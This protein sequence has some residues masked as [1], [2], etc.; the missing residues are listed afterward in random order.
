[1]FNALDEV[2]DDHEALKQHLGEAQNLNRQKLLEQEE[3]E[4]ECKEVIIMFDMI[5]SNLV[6]CKC[7]SK[8]LPDH[9]RWRWS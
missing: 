1:M 7:Q 4:A 3:A 2:M 8:S 9:S 5:D 6:S